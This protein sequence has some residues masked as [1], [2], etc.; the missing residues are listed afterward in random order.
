MSL[1]RSKV[2]ERELD[3]Q[4]RL[5]WEGK[6]SRLG[7]IC[8]HMVEEELQHRGEMNALLWQM[9]VDPPVSKYEDWVRAKTK[10]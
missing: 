10:G 5:P 6:F 3:R 1:R 2:S 7:D 4:V 9:N 8:R